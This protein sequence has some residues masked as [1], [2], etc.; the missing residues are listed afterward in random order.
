[1][2]PWYN[3]QLLLHYHHVWWVVLHL[4]HVM[5]ILF[6]PK[7]HFKDKEQQEIAHSSEKRTFPWDKT[8]RNHSN[9]KARALWHNL[10]SVSLNSIT[11]TGQNNFIT[12]SLL[13]SNMVKCSTPS[14][15]DCFHMEMCGDRSVKAATT[16]QV[17]VWDMLDCS[18][19]NPSYSS[20]QTHFFPHWKS[21]SVQIWI[22]KSLLI[23][24]HHLIHR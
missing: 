22:P 20:T 13:W 7:K 10:K 14:S 1:M 6:C 3:W 17:T 16:A 2:G 23:W 12:R 18:E 4:K 15:T 24:C 8:T 19:E 21:C 5:R 9:N 11:N